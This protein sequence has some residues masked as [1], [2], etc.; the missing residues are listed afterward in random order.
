V[1]QVTKERNIPLIV[2]IRGKADFSDEQKDLLSQLDKVIYV[3]EKTRQ[4]SFPGDIRDNESVVYNGRSLNEFYFCEEK[5]RVER[6]HFGLKEGDVVVAMIA[7]FN[8]IKG[9]DHFV[10]LAWR[11][12]EHD[13]LKFFLI[14]DVS[15]ANFKDYRSDIIEMIGHNGLS[16]KITLTG[17]QD[18]SEFVSFI[19]ILA[20][21]SESEGLPG[22]IIEAM[23][24][25]R[26][27]VSYD[28]G[29]IPEM[30]GEDGAGIY[31]EKGNIKKMEE[32]IILL[33]GDSDLR[34]EMG[35]KARERA[36]LLFC[37]E[38]HTQDIS[39]IYHSLVESPVVE[40]TDLHA[41]SALEESY[42]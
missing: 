40:S 33:I 36:D 28:V 20:V 34:K 4:E 14:G 11:L 17:F 37:I 41:T 8:P 39:E 38:R 26:C 21:P 9:F 10:E 42:A 22:V 16:N 23:A 7:S 6:E 24:A 15:N 19:D 13:H 27:I 25:G 2:H 12:K 29:G 35:Q 1:R 18:V 5:R 30:I 3:S 32:N 31:V